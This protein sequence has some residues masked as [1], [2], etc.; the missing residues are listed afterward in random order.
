MIL[1]LEKPSELLYP[2]L[3]YFEEVLFIEQVLSG[4]LTNLKHDD[5]IINILLN[6]IAH[7]N[8][9]QNKHFS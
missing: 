8:L 5:I 9:K 6:I 4:N 7:T 3:E 1:N 2:P